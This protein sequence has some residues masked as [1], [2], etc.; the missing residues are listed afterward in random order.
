MIMPAVIIADLTRTLN[1]KIPQDH[2]QIFAPDMRTHVDHSIA[3]VV[4]I[5]PSPEIVVECTAAALR[6]D[7]LPQLLVVVGIAGFG[8]ALTVRSIER[9]C[10]QLTADQKEHALSFRLFP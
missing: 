6:P 1:I 5:H 4:D 2:A 8:D 10:E 7:M 3:L 9:D